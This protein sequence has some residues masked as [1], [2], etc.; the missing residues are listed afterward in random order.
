MS[1]TTFNSVKA[2]RREAAP[3][4]VTLLLR[5]SLDMTQTARSPAAAK[6]ARHRH[7]IK[8]ELRLI[9]EGLDALKRDIEAMSLGLLD[10]M[11]QSPNDKSP[12]Q[13]RQ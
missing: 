11:T 3:L 10:Q 6:Q 4:R 2:S 9:R 5:Y 8:A 12:P 1:V 13:E 7:G